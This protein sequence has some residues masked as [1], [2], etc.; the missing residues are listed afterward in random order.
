MSLGERPKI[1]CVC[2][3]SAARD[4][5]NGPLWFRRAGCGGAVA[6]FAAF[7]HAERAGFSCR[8]CRRTTS[9][10]Y[11]GTND[12][13]RDDRIGTPVERQIG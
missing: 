12:P 10:W 9:S 4:V 11:N 5:L 1:R 7:P 8:W 3:V 13:H 6:R 2:S